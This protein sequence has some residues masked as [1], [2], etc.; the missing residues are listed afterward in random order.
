MSLPGAIGVGSRN[1]RHELEGIGRACSRDTPTPPSG[2]DENEERALARL[3]E[4]L[5]TPLAALHAHAAGKVSFSTCRLH[6]ESVKQTQR[7]QFVSRSIEG[8]LIARVTQSA[9]VGEEKEKEEKTFQEV[10]FYASYLPPFS[11]FLISISSVPSEYG[12]DQS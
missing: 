12:S 10:L 7:R 6:G 2:L 8:P 1:S 9:T 11:P 4:R 5:L 3:D